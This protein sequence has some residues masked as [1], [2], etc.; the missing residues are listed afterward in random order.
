[1]NWNRSP[2]FFNMLLAFC[3]ALPI[4]AQDKPQA[5][6]PAEHVYSTARGEQLKVY[7]FS[8]PPEKASAP[9]AAIVIFHGGGWSMG[10]PSWGFWLAQHF[11]EHGMVG[12]AAQ[13][14]LSD[15]KTTTP[16]DAM[17]DA[18]AAIRWIRANATSLGVDPNRIAAYG[19]SSGGHLAA[20]AA[21]FDDP[22]AASSVSCSPNALVLVSPAVSLGSDA[23]L[24]RLLISKA[25]PGSISP[26][27]HVRK[28]L[29]PTIILEGRADTVT[30]L[31]GV[32]HFCDR[33]QAE[34]NR[35]ELNIFDGVGHLFTPVGTPDDGFPKPDPTVQ[36]AAGAKADQFL[37]SLR[38]MK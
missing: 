6:G 23:W 8:S 7:V 28:G 19:W 38:Y 29:P 22:S 4:L 11:A 15:Q 16:L 9:R 13:Y 2:F 27:E 26:D 5:A 17:A 20:A 14:R 31:A 3:L 10:E 37:V 33:M 32:Q 25:D 24:K 1:V 21:I 30:P 35:C 36:A 34:H 18:R 12:I